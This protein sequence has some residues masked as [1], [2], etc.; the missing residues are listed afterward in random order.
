MKKI[1]SL[2]LSLMILSGGVYANEKPELTV[3]MAG[4]V[5]GT[6]NKFNAQF[7]KD[8][9]KYYDVKTIPGNSESKG[10]KIYQNITDR[11]VYVGVKSAFHSA[12]QKLQ[13]KEQWVGDHTQHYWVLGAKFYRAVCVRN[14]DN[15]DTLFFG[16]NQKNKIAF[17]DGVD[18]GNKFIEK[19]NIQTKS[20]NVMVPYNSSGKSVQG[21]ITGDLDI[22][23]VNEG[24]AL[25]HWRDK[26][27]NCKYT[28]NPNGGNGLTPLHTKMDDPWV[29]FKLTYVMHGE[30][31][32]VSK[33]FAE[34]LNANIQEIMSDPNSYTSKRLK[35]TGWDPL[36]GDIKT[37]TDDWRE[38]YN[39]AIK[40]L[41]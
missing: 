1:L 24:T 33:E 11:P 2:L 16:T 14:T 10:Y 35:V 21:L 38:T 3:V 28:S 15:V 7:V 17:T 32:N 39:T 22:T 4:S 30:V 31:K 6:F 19:L 8:L 5:G 25:K 40:T 18:F 20:A 41:D 36:V 23:F 34:E 27:I 29:G 13:G 37:I 26:N 12:I 9:E